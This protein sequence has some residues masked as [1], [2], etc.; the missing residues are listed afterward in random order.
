MREGYIQ[1]VKPAKIP[2]YA[3][4]SPEF[5]AKSQGYGVPASYS[6]IGI[7]YNDEL[8]KAAADRP[9]PTCGPPSIAAQIGIPRASSNLGLG[10]LVIGGE[11]LRRL[12]RQ[13]GAGLGRSCRS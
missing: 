13:S 10:F 12:G 7:A 8:L 1:K 5:V 9:G 3:N 6:L 2:N 4:V 11:G